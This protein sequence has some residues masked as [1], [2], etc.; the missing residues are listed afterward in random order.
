MKK[1][2]ITIADHPRTLRGLDNEVKTEMADRAGVE[3]ER[4]WKRRVDMGLYTSPQ[5]A[6]QFKPVA[7][8]IH[9]ASAECMSYLQTDDGKRALFAAMLEGP[10]GYIPTKSDI[11]FCVDQS[12]EEDTEV[13]LAIF[14]MFAEAFP[15]V[16]KAKTSPPPS[17]DQGST[18]N[19]GESSATNPSTSPTP[20]TTD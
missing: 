13:G 10:S 7:S 14:A 8:A 17:T 9:F 5:E 18:T 3:A 4:A 16:L 6:A 12:Y 1:Y 11:Q 20:S 19:G 2:K 15:K